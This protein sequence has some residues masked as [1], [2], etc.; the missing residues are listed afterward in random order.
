M[1]D[2]TTLKVMIAG[3]EQM[4]A[5]FIKTD[6]IDVFFDIPKNSDI[7]DETKLKKAKDAFVKIIGVGLKIRRIQ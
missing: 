5:K 3:M 7:D 4:G 1:G 6:G 2:L